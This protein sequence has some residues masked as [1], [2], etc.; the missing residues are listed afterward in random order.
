[1]FTLITDD[2]NIWSPNTNYGY[3]NIYLYQ[4]NILPNNIWVYNMWVTKGGVKELGDILL[5][6]RGETNDSI[7]IIAPENF[8]PKAL[9][10]GCIEIQ[11]MVS[12]TNQPGKK[13]QI[14]GG[15]KTRTLLRDILKK[16][17]ST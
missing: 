16:A 14:Q 9:K 2:V 1:M 3:H 7:L 8:L 4:Y 11:Q 12:T 17:T 6:Q 15:K 5:V 10:S 13:K